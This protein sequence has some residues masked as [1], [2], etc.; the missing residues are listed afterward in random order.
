V[1]IDITIRDALGRAHQ[2]ATVQLDFQLPINFD[3]TYKGYVLRA[4]VGV[5]LLIGGYCPHASEP[6]A[7]VAFV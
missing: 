4:T 1:Q 5:L 2:C 6:C 3:L 7:T